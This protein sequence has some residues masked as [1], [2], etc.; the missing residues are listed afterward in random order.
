M[1]GGNTVCRVD[2]DLLVAGQLE[3]TEP[4][5]TAPPA[6]QKAPP[7]SWGNPTQTSPSP[8]SLRDILDEEAAQSSASLGAGQQKGASGDG[9]PRPAGLSHIVCFLPSFLYCVQEV[10]DGKHL[11]KLPWYCRQIP[12]CPITGAANGALDANRRAVHEDFRRRRGC[13]RRYHHSAGGSRQEVKAYRGRETGNTGAQRASVACCIRREPASWCFTAAGHPGSQLIHA[14]R[15][16][17][18]STRTF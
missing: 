9:T 17:L 11:H 7:L 3:Q 4:K 13:L 2:L 16:V 6:V 15:L 5:P 10:A 18:R 12:G 14:A 1:N 8:L